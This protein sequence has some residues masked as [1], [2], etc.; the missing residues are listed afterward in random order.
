MLHTQAHRFSLSHIEDR[1]VLAS[2]FYVWAPEVQERG[3]ERET[4]GVDEVAV[5]VEDVDVGAEVEALRSGDDA[6]GFCV[7]G[8]GATD[9]FLKEA[10]EEDFRLVLSV[11]QSD[12]P[13]TH[14][15]CMICCAYLPTSKAGL[16]MGLSSVVMVKMPSN[17]LSGYGAVNSHEILAMTLVLPSRTSATPYS[18]PKSSWMG[19]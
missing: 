14:T 7:Q 15:G 2:Y 6:E 8:A 17:F 5:V 18:S 1:D 9:G 10:G 3:Y 16:A 19:L 12:Y 13:P 4:R 11:Y